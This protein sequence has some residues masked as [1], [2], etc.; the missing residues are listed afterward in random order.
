M[1][2]SEVSSY[3]ATTKS[4]SGKGV[5]VTVDLSFP[6]EFSQMQ[7]R[8]TSTSTST[9]TSKYDSDRFDKPNTASLADFPHTSP[10]ASVASSPV[11]SK[12]PLHHTT[13]D[14]DGTQGSPKIG[15]GGAT[16]S[17]PIYRFF[18]DA[19]HTIASA[20]G[21]GSDSPTMPG[22]EEVSM[23]RSSAIKIKK[24]SWGSPQDDPEQ[25]K[26]FEEKKSQYID[27]QD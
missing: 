15:G 18:K 7:G 10:S 25:R 3:A 26:R 8:P 5:T 22:G 27:F 19:Y 2:D 23:S 1:S 13:K 17:S 9:S 6:K 16:D 24:V 20:S 12:G 21:S 4:P 14:T 11:E